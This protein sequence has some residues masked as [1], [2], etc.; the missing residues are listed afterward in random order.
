MT[1]PWILPE[2]YFEGPHVTVAQIKSAV[3]D[4]YN[5]RPIEMVSARRGRDVARPRQVAMYLTREL[6]PLSFPNIGRLFGRR[7]HTTAMYAADIIEKRMVDDSELRAKVKEIR[8]FLEPVE[9]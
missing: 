1:K 6:T 4:A 2:G 8:R 5:L 3:C 9:A 7:D